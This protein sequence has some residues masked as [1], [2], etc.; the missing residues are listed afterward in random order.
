MHDSRV[1]RHTTL[2][3][4]ANYNQILLEAKVNV[5][6]Q[7]IGPMFLGDGIYPQSK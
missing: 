5:N 3:H 2:C 7:E 6:D 1:L 4:R